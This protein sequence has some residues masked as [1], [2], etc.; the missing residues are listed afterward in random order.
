MNKMMTGLLVAVLTV[1]LVGCADMSAQNK[2]VAIGAGAGAVGG[3]VIGNQMGR[4][5]GAIGALV[6]AIAGATAGGVYGTQVDENQK[7]AQKI[8]QQN[9]KINEQNQALEQKVHRISQLE[10][11]AQQK[12]IETNQTQIWRDPSSNMS[13]RVSSVEVPSNNS[14]CH[15]Q[16]TIFT[17]FNA[18]QK[19]AETETVT[20]TC[21]RKQ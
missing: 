18:G 3:A 7:Q 6:G 11:Q 19:V 20:E 16:K 21:S 17:M 15:S 1:G 10:K 5:G 2:G 4:N 12:A 13:G 8:D 9:Q 14:N